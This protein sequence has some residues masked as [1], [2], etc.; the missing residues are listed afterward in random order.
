MPNINIRTRLIIIAAVPLL[1]VL[2]LLSKQLIQ[3]N[4]DYRHA[5]TSHE[6]I[7]FF[8][9]L[10]QV[11]HNFA[12]E[13]GLT[14]GFVASNGEKGKSAL[15][16][17]R[18]LA[19]AAHA[20]MVNFTPE[21]L[22]PALVNQLMS[23]IQSQLRNKSAMRSQ[24]DNL[25]LSQSPFEYYSTLNK[26]S[27]DSMAIVLTQVNSQQ[28]TQSM[29]G[30]LS[31]L[32]M[33]E[34][35]GKAR[36]S[37]NGAFAGKQSSL[38]KY[39]NITAYIASEKFALRQAKLTLPSSGSNLLS[40]ATN[41]R[42]WQQVQSI[43]NQYLGQKQTLSSLEGPEASTWFSLATK[44]I[45]AIKNVADTVS[46]NV[47]NQ[48]TELMSSAAW[49][50]NIYIAICIFLVVPMIVLTIMSVRSISLRVNF[51]GQKIED[52]ASTKNLTKKL[53]DDKG[54]EF[55]NLAGHIDHL[56]ESLATPLNNAHDVASRTQLELVELN[57]RIVEAKTAS[58]NT[59]HR[60]DSIATAMT[61]MAQTSTQ[62]ADVTN[63]AQSTTDKA[64][65]NAQVCLNHS[66]Q[67][68]EATR[69]LHQNIE[70][71]FN[72]VEELEKQTLNVSQILD[73]ITAISEQT[74]LL[75]LNAAIEA[76]RAG[77]QGRGFAVVADE[78][79]TLAQRSQTATEDIRKLLD[80][81]SV[82]AKASFENMQE[83]KT[84]S[85]NTHESVDDTRNYIDSL[86]GAV[87]EISHFNINI[88]AAA[89]QQSE[90][91]NIVNAD[92]DELTGLVSSTGTMI[93]AVDEEIRVLETRMHEL[94]EQINS[95]TLS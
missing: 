38:D 8:N 78:V 37:L 75:A 91:A 11:A 81:I 27:L 60:C 73:T 48:A 69:Q 67:A 36:G 50:R 40:Q 95:F 85:D 71:T 56:L 14:A 25:S 43:Q 70:S 3:T 62:V 88:A 47:Q 79:R 53:T 5:A 9:L 66:A 34:E 41:S 44:R 57:Q 86:S 74:N 39:A 82:N 65:Q 6:A 92:L 33:K 30:L 24:V 2:F 94:T 4:Q 32:Q 80:D 10:D 51:F 42:E 12:V 16:N 49:A 22:D 28:L 29:Q 52:I 72:R 89:N 61:E 17:Q 54:D 7:T 93:D 55:S 76:A 64:S 45:G 77:E 13:R 63:E 35:A 58:Q 46:E 18:N 15:N 26:L 23:D 31:L 20:Q 1:L 90:T 59:F 21:Y 19:D 68:F 83:S 87:Q 84:A